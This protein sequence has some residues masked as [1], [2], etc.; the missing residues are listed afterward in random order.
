MGIIQREAVKQTIVNYAGVVIATVATL[1]IYPLDMDIYGLAQLLT[2][3]ALL[4]YPFVSLGVSSLTVRFFPEFGGKSKPGKGYLS[5]LFLWS[6][7][8]FLI[9]TLLIYLFQEPV[10]GLL[11]SLHF[12]VNLIEEYAVEILALTLLT[13]Y[14][15]VMAIYISNFQRIVVPA[16]LRNVSLKIALPILVFLHYLQIVN[17]PE[18]IYTWIVVHGLILVGLLRYAYSLGGFDWKLDVSFLWKRLRKMLDYG[19]FTWLTSVGNAVSVRIDIVMVGFLLGPV[20]AGIYSIAAFIANVIQIPTKAVW[21]ISAPLIAKVWDEEDKDELEKIY[22]KGSLNL[23]L[24]G[25]LMFILIWASLDPLFQITP[26]YETLILGLYAV[27]YLGFAK[28]LDMA[29]SVNT[30]IILYSRWYKVN[31]V[32]LLF[33]SVANIVLNYWLIDLMG[34]PGAALATLCSLFLFNLSKFI[35]IYWK[36][37]LQPFSLDTLKI[38]LVAGV[39][40]LVSLI[41]PQTPY[42]LVTIVLNSIVIIAIYLPIAYFWKI[43]PEFNDLL[44]KNLNRSGVGGE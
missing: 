35:F 25:I 34:L 27:L 23:L 7:V 24:P 20:E 42:P 1:F 14:I 22:Q 2:N 19:L 21:E 36:I 18:V 13:I 30:Q 29:S 8:W 31:I 44:R 39:T 26:R 10:F 37:G 15:S 16:L 5:V 38:L 4:L 9:F 28:M 11:S 43:S 3:T 33:V 40:Y 12:K 32:F 17:T 6:T 41:I